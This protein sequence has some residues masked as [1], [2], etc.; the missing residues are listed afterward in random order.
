MKPI[1]NTPKTSPR[2]NNELTEALLLLA[3]K[4]FF[5]DRPVPEQESKAL[6][7]RMRQLIDSPAPN[8]ISIPID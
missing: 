4:A 2:L 7:A 8:R 6:L 3:N 5:L 1:T